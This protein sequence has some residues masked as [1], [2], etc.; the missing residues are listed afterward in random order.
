MM[1][2]WRSLGQGIV[3]FR[4][5]IEPFACLNGSLH[6]EIVLHIDGE[7]VRMALYGT[8]KGSATYN[9]KLVTLEEPF[10]GAV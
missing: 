8:R 9:V 5:T 4:T 7:C 1:Y 3:L 2:T 6:G 10:F